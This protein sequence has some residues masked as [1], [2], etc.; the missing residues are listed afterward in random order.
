MSL[1]DS[2][3]CITV[4]LPVPA[5]PIKTLMRWAASVKSDVGQG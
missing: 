1:R 5:G 4:V 3:S 2:K